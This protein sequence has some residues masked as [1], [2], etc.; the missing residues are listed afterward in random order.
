MPA[1]SAPRDGS[2]PGSHATVAAGWRRASCSQRRR[3]THTIPLAKELRAFGFRALWTRVSDLFPRGTSTC[4]RVGAMLD[5][6]GGWGVYGRP[7][8][9]LEPEHE[10]SKHLVVRLTNAVM[11]PPMVSTPMVPM[12]MPGKADMAPRCPPEPFRTIPSIARYQRPTTM[13]SSNNQRGDRPKFEPPPEEQRGAGITLAPYIRHRALRAGRRPGSLPKTI[14][15]VAQSIYY[16]PAANESHGCSTVRP[17]PKVQPKWQR[18]MA[19]NNLE[20]NSPLC[21]TRAW[22][23]PARQPRK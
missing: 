3:K 20:G 6:S 11:Q 2:P 10:L 4:Q 9:A 19:A 5:T 17:P 22:P 15:P 21:S 13:P 7:S 8:R 14:S 18:I 23:P 16:N 1:Q 12:T